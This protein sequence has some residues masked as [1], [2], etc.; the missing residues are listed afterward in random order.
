MYL[1]AERMA[2]ANQTV[3]ETFEQTCVAWQTIPHWDVGD[4]GATRVRD[5]VMNKPSFIDLKP[6]A[7]PFQ[8]TLVQAGAPTPDS[9][10]SE[11]MAAAVKLA[12]KV[13][14]KIITELRTK[15]SKAVELPGVDPEP[16]NIIP[17]LID[18]RAHLEDNGF[19]A[20]TCLLTNTQGLKVLSAFVGG[21]PATES[22]LTAANVNALHRVSQLDKAVDAGGGTSRAA[23]VMLM[24]GRRQRIAHNAAADA[25]P[26]E[27]PVDLAISVM[28]GV[29]VL[30][31]TTGGHVEVEVR[32]RFAIRVKD[33]T[34][35]VAVV[36]EKN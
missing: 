32:I 2:L 28:P 4:P 35:I 18:A 25:S 26:G 8:L 19:R 10:L 30:G 9:L 1:S 3:M 21:Y 7:E 31:E 29:A 20:P 33:A 27:E 17:T 15:A 34:G 5:D 22:L 14:T 23:A 12:G 6:E 13:D 16:K 24:L 36:D 11:V